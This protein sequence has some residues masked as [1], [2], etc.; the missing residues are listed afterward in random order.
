M[1]RPHIFY[2]YWVLAAAFATCMVHSSPVGYTFGFFVKPLQTE[3]GWGRGEIMLGCMLWSLLGGSAA[4]LAGWLV[5]RF[6]GRKVVLVGTLLSSAIFCC[7]AL[8]NDLWLFLLLW[9]VN[10]VVMTGTSP[11]STSTIVSNWFVR[12]RGLAIGVMAAGVGV[13]GLIFVPLVNSWLMPAFGWR[14]TFIALGLITGLVLVPQALFVMKDRPSDLGLNPDGAENA[15]AAGAREKPPTQ[16]SRGVKSALGTSAFWLIAAGF[17]FGGIGQSGLL[18]N[19]AP[20]LSDA[21]VDSSLISAALG[22]VGLFST[23]GKIFFGWLCQRINPKYGWAIAVTL[24]GSA[25]VTLLAISAGGRSELIW[26]YAVL[27]GLGIGGWL[28]TMSLLVSSS[29]GLAGYASIFGVISLV[30]GVG[31]SLGPITAGYIFDNTGSYNLAFLVFLGGYV[32]AAV[33][34][35]LIQHARAQSITA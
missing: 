31:S 8:V 16:G 21:R 22:A 33:A 2:G 30:L 5:D 17:F 12:R 23:C 27:F 3:L 35:L 15:R 4:P 29:F 14:A 24:Q 1:N 34:M 13:G 25:A 32:A 19:Q 10:G 28:P 11:V 7:L 6:G 18:Q 26:L 9:A 20:F